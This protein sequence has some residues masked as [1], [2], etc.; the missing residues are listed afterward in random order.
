MT[1]PRFALWTVLLTA[2]A[3]AQRD[4]VAIEDC[5]E[6]GHGFRYCQVAEDTHGGFEAS[7]HHSYLFYGEHKL[8]NYSAYTFLPN[9]EGI[10]WQ[11][12]PQPDFFLFRPAEGKV[13]AL[14]HNL[15]DVADKWRW[16]KDGHSVSVYLLNSK[17]WLRLPIPPV[18]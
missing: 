4:Y 5:R 11:S 6:L 15:W 7:M 17:Q 3:F 16:S 2:S 8:G 9:G 12:I 13:R 14:T 10:I 1:F 18:I